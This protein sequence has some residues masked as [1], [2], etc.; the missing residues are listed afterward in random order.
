MRCSYDGTNTVVFT[1]NRKD[2]NKLSNLITYGN[3]IFRGSTI[4][5]DAFKK[6]EGGQ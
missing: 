5:Q 6:A 3:G 2:L 4:L 1:F